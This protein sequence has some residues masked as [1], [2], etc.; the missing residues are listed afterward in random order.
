MARFNVARSSS[1][2]WPSLGRQVG[3]L[4]VRIWALTALLALLLL[5]WISAPQARAACEGA[6]TPEQ[7][8]TGL[9][10]PPEWA[11]ER[12]IHF[13]AESPEASAYTASEMEAGESEAEIAIFKPLG[14]KGFQP[15]ARV[16]I[17]EWTKWAKGL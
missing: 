5:G 6:C 8:E 13:E 12:E 16:K 4:E 9:A 3:P 11:A 1:S 2:N 17:E 7:A 14:D 10:E 15:V